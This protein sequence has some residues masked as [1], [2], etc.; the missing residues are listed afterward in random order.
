MKIWSSP[1]T[2]GV[3]G[4]F[5]EQDWKNLVDFL[6]NIGSLKEDIPTSRIYTMALVDEINKFD[7]DAII[8]QAKNFDPA[9]M[10]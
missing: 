7:R 3:N 2:N 8:K 5:V 9:S 1:A 4:A 10:K 6:K